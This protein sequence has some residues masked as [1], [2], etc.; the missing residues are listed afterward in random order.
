MLDF[1][2]YIGLVL[3]KHEV[4]EMLSQVR[5][6]LETFRWATKRGSNNHRTLGAQGGGLAPKTGPSSN[7]HNGATAHS[8][9]PK[10]SWEHLGS[11]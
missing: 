9:L 2:F 10:N 11:R 1:P 6:N 8:P 3:T 5:R 7:V 4:L